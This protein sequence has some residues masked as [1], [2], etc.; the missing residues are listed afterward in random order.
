MAI[1]FWGCPVKRF[2]A[3]LPFHQAPLRPCRPFKRPS[4]G[5]Q[6]CGGAMTYDPAQGT[7]FPFV[8]NFPNMKFFFILVFAF[9]P[10]YVIFLPKIGMSHPQ[11]VAL[12][13]SLFIAGGK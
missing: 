6:S 13:A 2:K 8:T 12:I 11:S 5:T 7:R 4:Y 3:S 1:S 10:N 9:F